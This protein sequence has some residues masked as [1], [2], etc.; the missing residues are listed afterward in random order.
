VNDE[1]KNLK[2]FLSD[3]ALSAETDDESAWFIDSGASAHMT[4][5]KEW[6]DKYYE[7]SDGTHIYLGDDR[8]LKVQGYGIINVYLPNGQMRQIHNVMYVPALK[9]NLISV[10]TI[11][12]N[13]LKVEFGK[14]GC[15]VKDVQDHYRVVSTGTRV[16]GLYR[17][18]VTVKR[19]VALTSTE[20]STAELWHHRYGHLNY[21][22]LSLLQR[23][24][25]VE[26]LPVMRCEHLPCE[27]CALGKQHRE[28][29]PVHTEKR[30]YD[31]LELIH[32]DVCGPMHTRSLGGASYFV[33][34]ID[35]R[36]RY[37][38]VYFIRRK[39]DIFEYFK[40]FRTMV[41][42]QTGKCIKILRSDQGGEYKSKAFNI[43]CKSNG[44]QQQFTVPH[45]PQ[46]NGVAERWNRTLV[47]SARSMLQGKNISNSFW[48][49]AVNT[50]V[51][52]KNRCP[53]KQLVFKTP[54]EVLHDYKPDV[55]H[56]K[57]FGCTAFA[58]IPKAN[59][60]KLDAKSI[61]CV[62]IGYCTDQKAYKLFDPSSH[63]LFASR[64]VVFHEQADKSNT[65]NDAWHI[66]NDAHIKIDTLIKQ[67]QE[68]VQDLDDSSSMS[69]SSSSES[70]QGGD[71]PQRQRIMD[72]T[73]EGIDAPRRSSR[74]T[75]LPARYRDYA[76][77][78]NIMNVE[79]PIDYEQAKQ[80]EPW[81]NAMNDEYASLMKNQTWE[82][83]ELPENKVPI[84]SKWLYKTKFKADGTIDKFKA[85]LVAKGY[86]QQE[87]IDYE[88][89][90]APV[91]K[92]NTI[93]LL[94]ALA[95]KHHWNI[96]QLDVKSAFLN[97]DLKE[98]VYLVQPEGFVKQGQEHLVCR[99]RKALYGLKQAPRSWYVKIDTFFLQNGFVKSKNDPNLYV[100]KD[101]K[102]NVALIS[103][104]VDDLIITGSAH[105]LIEEIKVQL[106]QVFEMK[107][108]GE[109]HYCLGIEV[110]REPGKTLITQ[111]KYTKEILK[112]FNM[113]ACKAMSTPLE[114]NAKLYREDG[115]KEADGTLYRQLV[116]SLNYLTTTRPDIAYS[117]SILS[118]FMAKPSGNHWNAAKKV[119]RYLKGTV[120]LGIMY[121]D[122][123]D[124]VL[125]GFSDSDWAGNPDDRRSTSGYAFH[126][127]SGVVSW[128]SKKQP[129][130]SLSSTES[131]YKALTNATCE[132]IW[133]R[134][135]L[136]DLEEAQSG[137]TCI[138]CD[139]QSAI[140]LAHN[141]VYHARTK[142][143]ELQYHF[144]REKIESNE[145]GLIF[146]N[147]KDNVADIF[148]K[149]LGKIKFE[150]F[151]SQ[152][153]IV[154]NP[155][156][157]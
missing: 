105:K 19:H 81:I 103:L 25:M 15:I 132:A 129:T 59:R 122:E 102:G 115:S 36:S 136:A 125:T 121:T 42:K 34:F 73:P 32:T 101:E 61:K 154:E 98:E 113:T 18:D 1:F 120:N 108:L 97:G 44:I 78:S 156:L 77:M 17:L 96:H 88:D 45:T 52:L 119:L 75:R 62:F 94:I 153:G 139:N 93:R 57:V 22:D 26:G 128:S 106:S 21:N 69:T 126:I 67:E 104:Y 47:E 82:L 30:K 124:V 85:R 79:E 117:V 37:T 146:C 3:A 55:S 142:H 151:R 11:T 145:I 70:S 23:K 65:K 111:S 4:C 58:H 131:E 53:T 130:V 141:P 135:I 2:L 33:I 134:R 60:R 83:V 24:S 157:H 149:P 143:V 46:Q 13:H 54:F 84:G 66:S 91:A 116:G 74:Q 107:D 6:Y 147:T 28:E 112:K 138:N 72:G 148:T 51:Y 86:A 95:T 10:S 118:Q 152:L 63:K 27:A 29:F 144:V 90:F 9:K 56:F 12:D 150:V 5:N 99:L 87:G 155:F 39:S 49:E 16:G 43:Y 127:G 68:Q 140:K 7:K 20:T 35:D 123:S 92:L 50:A 38:W 41:E 48:A 89:T 100:K 133:L 8:S 109:L 40:E 64:D 76:L 31:I 71:S 110:W 114:Q 80:H 14:F 137:S